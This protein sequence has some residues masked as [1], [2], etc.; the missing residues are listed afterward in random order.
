LVYKLGRQW[1]Q[2]DIIFR[3]SCLKSALAKMIAADA[4]GRFRKDLVM[5]EKFACIV[6]N[7]SSTPSPPEAMLVPVSKSGEDRWLASHPWRSTFKRLQDGGG[8]F[9]YACNPRAEQSQARTLLLLPEPYSQQK[10][11]L[12]QPAGFFNVATCWGCGEPSSP[13]GFPIDAGLGY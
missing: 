11:L 2:A 12:A 5:P 3:Q 1:S 9:A 8:E 7:R 4:T 10:T 13:W 6:V